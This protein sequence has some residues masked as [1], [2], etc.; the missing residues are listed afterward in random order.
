MRALFVCYG[1]GHVEMC[2]P[3][4]QAL[5][6]LV[7]GCTATIMAL[8]TAYEAARGAGETPLGYRD[9]AQGP[10]TLPGA[11]QALEYG[12][13][14]LPGHEHPCVAPQE[15]QAYLGFNFL[16]WVQV[17]GETGARERWREKGRYG[18]RPVNFFSQ[19]LQALKPDV[20]VSTNAPRSEQAVIEAASALGIPSLCMVDLFAL[21]GDPFLQRRVHAQRIAV[22]AE[23]TQRNLL[24]AGVE[25]S[26]IVV[27]G[28]AAFDA[29][30]SPQAQAEGA[31][32]RTARGWQD[33]HVVLWAGHKEPLDAQPAELAGMRLGEMVQH[34]LVDWVLAR[35]D[36]CLVVRYHPNEWH[37]FSPP[38]LHPRIHWS[39][40]GSEPLLPVLLGSDQVVV[41]ATSVGV[42]ASTAGKR[43]LSLDFSPLVQRSG[44]DYARFGVAQGV[45]SLDQLVPLLSQMPRGDLCPA[46][47]AARA[48]NAAMAIARHIVEL[49]KGSFP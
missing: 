14:L 38:P 5:R 42:Q 30:K 24:A 2:L 10:L 4:M 9:F 25:P 40:P 49:V 39:C 26:R 6:Q 35:D 21:P 18:F 16:E 17:L 47:V 13:E 8:T 12:L 27:T 20:V 36:L 48:P 32:W 29:L 34:R 11:A 33:R 45:P 7:Q 19:V 46:G 3:V 1:G 44:M 23:A 28:N 15:S 37:E 22:W 31:K 41:Q 43:V